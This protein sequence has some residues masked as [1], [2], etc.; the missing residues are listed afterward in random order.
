MLQSHSVTTRP[1]LHIEWW[2]NSLV[3]AAI[4][5]ALSLLLAPRLT[6]TTRTLPVGGPVPDFNLFLMAGGNFR[7]SEALAAG[8]P[9]LLLFYELDCE[10]SERALRRLNDINATRPDLVIVAVNGRPHTAQA[11]GQFYAQLTAA[12]GMA[13]R[14]AW[15]LDPQGRLARAYHVPDA[16][17][18][19]FFIRA[20]GTLAAVRVGE[21]AGHNLLYRV[22]QYLP[23]E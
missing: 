5:M 12:S 10:P 23:P 6:R 11:L 2:R 20:D 8:R 1:A 14:F 21:H 4:V 17:P 18:F 13:P 3:L 9:V 16:Y 19:W 22:N 7:L 15:G